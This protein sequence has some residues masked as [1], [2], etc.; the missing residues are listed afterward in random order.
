MPRYFFHTENGHCSRDVEGEV[1]ADGK[2]ARA[3]ALAVLGEILRYQG[4]AFFETGAF[5]VT[6]TDENRAEVVKLTACVASPGDA[7]P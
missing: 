6:V 7:L 1:L 2:A 4:D 5:S 3:E